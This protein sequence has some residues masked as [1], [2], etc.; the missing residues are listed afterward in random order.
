M[1]LCFSALAD[2]LCLRVE[3]PLEALEPY[4]EELDTFA[5]LGTP[6]G[7]KGTSMDRSIPDKIRRARRIIVDFYRSWIQEGSSKIES[8]ARAK[9][10]AIERGS[11]LSTWSA[12]QLWDVPRRP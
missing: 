6:V 12:F 4:W 10:A 5:L 1:R 2:L 9:R 3:E 8:L 11:P 7:T